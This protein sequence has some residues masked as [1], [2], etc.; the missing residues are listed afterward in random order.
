MLIE[1]RICYSH[2][3]SFIARQCLG[4]GSNI[5]LLGM[6]HMELE[7]NQSPTNTLPKNAPGVPQVLPHV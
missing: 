1:A 7:S 3:I 5:A 2:S 6:R 4:S